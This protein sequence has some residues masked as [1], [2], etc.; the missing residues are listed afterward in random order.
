MRAEIKRSVMETK[1]PYVKESAVSKMRKLAQRVI[2]LA[3]DYGIAFVGFN[4]ATGFTNFAAAGLDNTTATGL[5][6]ATT[7]TGFDA[8]G[9][10]PNFVGGFLSE[11]HDVVRQLTAE[12]KSQLRDEQNRI[13]LVDCLEVF[14]LHVAGN[15]AQVEAE[16]AFRQWQW[17]DTAGTSALHKEN[18]KM[19][20]LDLLQRDLLGITS[21]IALIRGC[22]DK[23]YRY[24]DYVLEHDFK[25][26]HVSKKIRIGHETM[27][28]IVV[29]MKEK[30]KKLKRLYHFHFDLP[31][32]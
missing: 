2:G 9:G 32:H 21:R 15:L 30:G 3:R 25:Y 16:L 6:I 27:D 18:I 1:D 23:L 8:I 7:G 13:R 17:R 4:T 29:G 24:P 5:N 12:D 14:H 20:K 11:M 10:T 26:S 28:A 22:T 19:E 31:K